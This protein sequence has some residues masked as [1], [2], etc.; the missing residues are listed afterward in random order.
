MFDLRGVVRAD[1]S[2]EDGMA[3]TAREVVRLMQNATAYDEFRGHGPVVL[4]KALRRQYS[5]HPA[6]WPKYGDEL[7]TR[8]LN[9]ILR[10]CHSEHGLPNRE[11]V[12]RR[13]R[14]LGRSA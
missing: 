8:I 13:D 3:A 4:E 14:N 5:W 11:A 6:V 1:L 9:Q 10:L 12:G 2:S 7:R